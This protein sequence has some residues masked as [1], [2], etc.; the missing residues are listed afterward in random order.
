MQEIT[1]TKDLAR[2]CETCAKYDYVTVDT[3]FLRERS[4][5]S[6]LCLIQM[7]YPSDD[8]KAA[9]LIDPLAEGID[10]KP[11]YELFDNK[12]VTKVFHA[13]RQDLEIFFYETKRF[14]KPFFDT[15]VAGMVCGYGDQV[16][17][18]RLVKSI[19]GAGI[20][21]SSRFT[22]WQ[23]RPLNKRQKTYALA[24]VTH[25]RDVY[26]HLR[27][28]LAKSGRAAWVEE[29]LQ[30]LTDPKTYE[31]DPSLAWR[32]V[33]TRN[34]NWKLKS[35]VI[36]LARFREE[37]AQK[38]NLPRG[39]IFKDDA[40]LEIAAARPKSVKDL[41]KLRLLQ[42]D[43][44]KGVIADGIVAAIEAASK[45][46]ADDFV[47]PN[48]KHKPKKGREGVIELLRV[49]LKARCEEFQVA[50][51]LI[52]SSAD[53]ESIAY[54]ETENPVFQG[55]RNEV[56]GQ[57]AKDLIDGKVALAADGKKIKLISL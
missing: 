30:Q 6:K 9:A 3:E 16:G 25:L 32:R 2:F 27:D 11:L 22:D 34:P 48:I 53:I 5:Y 47:E 23:A 55:W 56:F 40:L 37:R 21:K 4:Y 28:E 26:E 54:G 51:K 44:R 7:A 45:Y 46:K 41:G 18:D 19:T 13:A 14:P 33:K 31:N 36:E 49:L 29:E 38:K 1:T 8:E 42:R 17:Y 35:A 43:G 15:Q 39:R 10:L 20:D 24:D 57:A 52:T 50:P 12:N